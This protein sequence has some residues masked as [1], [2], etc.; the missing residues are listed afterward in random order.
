MNKPFYSELLAGFLGKLKATKEVDGTSLFDHVALAYGSNIRGLAWLMVFWT[1]MAVGDEIS[2]NRDIQPIL[3]ENC[4]VCHGPDESQRLGGFR[5]DERASSIV[6]ADSGAIPIVPHDSAASEVVVRVEADDESL[7]MPPP[8]SDKQLTADQIRKLRQWID[9][10]AEYQQHWAFVAPTRPPLPQHVAGARNPIDLFIRARLAKEGLTPSVEADR[11]TLLRR[12]TLDLIGLPPTPSE[13]KDFLADASPGAYE[14][15]VDRLLASP[16]YGER[17]AV[18]WLDYARFADSNGFQSDGSREMWLWRDWVI[19]AFNTNLPFDQFTIEQLA[20][21]RLPDATLDQIVATGFNRNHRL[22]GEGGRIVEEWFAETVIDRVETTGLT[23]L[24]LTFNCC[25]CHDHKYDP[26]SQREFYQLFAY[27]NS[28]DESGVLAA[29]GINGANT[30]PLLSLPTPSQQLREQDLE[31]EVAATKKVL[32]SLRPQLPE[33]VSAWAAQERDKRLSNEL[34]RSDWRMLQPTYVQSIKG[35]KFRRLEDGSYLAIGNNRDS[36]IYEISAPIAVEKDARFLGGLL[37]E[38]M[39]HE[40]LPGKSLGRGSNGNFVLTGVSAEISS[41]SY[42]EPQELFFKVAQADFEQQ[43]WTAQSILGDNPRPGKPGKR[44]KGWAVEGL[45]PENRVPRKVMFVCAEPFAL[46]EDA[47][48]KITMRH[49]SPF[50]DHNVGR[51]RWSLSSLPPTE[52]QLSSAGLPAEIVALIDQSSD[53]WTDADLE[54]LTKYFQEQVDHP[55]KQAESKLQSQNKTLQSHR[56]SYFS[57]MVMREGEPRQ[58]HILV[59]GEYDQ[60]GPPVQR[61]VPA[62]FGEG[63]P[64]QDRLELARWI[65]SRSNPL[66]ARVWVNRMWEHFFGT[67]IVKTSENLG[68]QA[69]FPVHPELLD[70]LAVEF[71][72][73][74]VATDLITTVP[75]AWDM[76]ALQKL[77]VMSATYRQSAGVDPELL[78]RDPEN[79]LL[80]RGPRFRLTGEVIRDSALAAGGLLIPTIGGPSA[81]PYMPAGVWDE[82]SVYGNLRNYQHDAGEGLHRRTMYTIWK[83]TA[84]PPTMLLFDAP[85]RETCTIKRDKTNTPLQALSLLNEVTFVEAAR[86]LATRMIREGGKSPG[87]RIAYGFQLALSRSPTPDESLVLLAGLE[88]DLARYA[89]DPQAAGKLVSF[90]EASVGNKLAQGELAAYTLTANVLLN[91]DEFITKE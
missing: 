46:P 28:V 12:V 37:L 41:S 75:N 40:S 17:M 70:W 30:P 20:G 7:R 59:R 66:T 45:K 27:F 36:D 57:T 11:E 81:R 2:F 87:E 43:G 67:G 86:A 18:P 49:D 78:D 71:M 79:R 65:V 76:K 9:S 10:G 83:R 4:F 53:Q 5:L 39:P 29:G 6:E 89:V 26:I 63:P 69:E 42:A 62:V 60:I 23:W 24:G 90:G 35:A 73:P 25:R 22:N 14:R 72:E 91:L 55:I 8:E 19:N 74:T 21:D 56:E 47:E 61:G 88:E 51:F 1:T 50:P 34:G 82:T 80:A 16:H 13:L 58:A 52:I 32:A 48:I 15:V 64:P 54:L 31:R 44:R 33:L 68:L 84:A 85:N 77:M 3:S 38:V